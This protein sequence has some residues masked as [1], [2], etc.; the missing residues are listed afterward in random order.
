MNDVDKNSVYDDFCKC[1]DLAQRMAFY[2]TTHGRDGNFVG[3]VS[4]RLTKL[5]EAFK[6][7]E[8]SREEN[9]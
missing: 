3:T 8:E 9:Q 5:F 2:E 1:Y 7:R 4:E 6:A